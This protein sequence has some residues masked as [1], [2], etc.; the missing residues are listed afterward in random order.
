MKMTIFDNRYV[1]E[2]V[3]GPDIGIS[4]IGLVQFNAAAVELLGLTDDKKVLLV[5]DKDKLGDWYI[6]VTHGTYGIRIRKFK[7]SFIFQSKYITT[8]FLKSCGFES[9]TYR[10]KISISPLNIDGV[11][12]YL[13]ITKSAHKSIYK[14]DG[15]TK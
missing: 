6:M 3:L 12:Y 5:Q 11:P 15:N 4:S 14:K 8:T 2:R 1:N 9:A 13:I 10:M 7:K